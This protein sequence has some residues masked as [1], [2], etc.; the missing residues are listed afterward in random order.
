MLEGG[1]VK[2]EKFCE[3][4]LDEQTHEYINSK[5]VHFMRYVCRV[6]PCNLNAMGVFLKNIV[7]K[8]GI[9]VF[10]IILETLLRLYKAKHHLMQSE[11]FYFR[12]YDE[13]TS[14]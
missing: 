7:E 8:I 1:K 14:Q 3:G 10:N 13:H 2:E 11:K 9:F 12:L 6:I 5:S 4:C